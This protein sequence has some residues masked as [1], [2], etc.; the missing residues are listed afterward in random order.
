[1]IYGSDGECRSVAWVTDGGRRAAGCI[2][3]RNQNKKQC[4]GAAEMS[5]T[6]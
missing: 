2:M 4:H 6:A 5:D 1:M 3:R